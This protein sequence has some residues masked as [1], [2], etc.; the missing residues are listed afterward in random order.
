MARPEKPAAMPFAQINGAARVA[1]MQSGGFVFHHLAAFACLLRIGIAAAKYG[2]RYGWRYGGGWQ[3]KCRG[4]QG[5]QK[6]HAEDYL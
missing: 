1:A 3:Q 4:S 6:M 2:L 5:K